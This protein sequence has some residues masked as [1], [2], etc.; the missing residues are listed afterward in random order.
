MPNEQE[1]QS[2][3]SKPN[4]LQIADL[5]V[6]GDRNADYGH[7]FHDFSRTAKIWGAILGIDVTP[8]QVALCMVGVKISRE[9]NKPK[10]DNVI[11]GCGY[12][13]TLEMVKDFRNT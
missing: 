8:E 9:C 4:C 10:D 5:L 2:G 6:G 11:D 13:R 1:S 12:F 7:P 3:I